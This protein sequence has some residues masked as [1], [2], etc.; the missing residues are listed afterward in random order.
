MP[1]INR[2]IAVATE[3]NVLTLVALCALAQSGD[4]LLIVDDPHSLAQAW[5]ER[6]QDAAR[7]F[8]DSARI[9]RIT[10]NDWRP[11]ALIEIT[12]TALSEKWPGGAPRVMHQLLIGGRKH[13]ALLLHELMLGRCGPTLPLRVHSVERR[14]FRL[15]CSV[16][17]QGGEPGLEEELPRSR[18]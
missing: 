10:I 2:F 4:Q 6:L 7:S 9:R 5:G 3:I 14:P 8:M 18:T 11:S 16:R 15:E 13:P 17:G 1:S 12:E